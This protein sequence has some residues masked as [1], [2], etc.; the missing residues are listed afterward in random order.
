[1]PRI[2]C[3]TADGEECS[4]H[5][6]RWTNQIVLAGTD[7]AR[8]A[9]PELGASRRLDTF[10]EW[11]A[12]ST[13][14][15]KLVCLSHA[16]QKHDDC[17]ATQQRR[18]A[19]HNYCNN[20]GFIEILRVWN[21]SL[22]NNNFPGRSDTGLHNCC[23]FGSI[24]YKA[25][26]SSG[27]SGDTSIVMMDSP[28]PSEELEV[29]RLHSTISVPDIR[30]GHR[31]VHVLLGSSAPRYLCAANKIL[32]KLVGNPNISVR[33]I[34]PS[35]V[36]DEFGGLGEHDRCTEESERIA[37]ELCE[38][39][40]L[41]VLAPIEADAFARMLHGMTGNT[42][43]EV[44]R[45]WDVSKKAI[46]VPG[47][48]TA[49]WKNPMT[50]KQLNKV[51]R[52]WNWVRVLQPM[53]WQFEGAETPPKRNTIWEGMEE[54]IGIIIN[55][56]E[57]MIIGQ[58]VDMTTGVST[59]TSK[60]G[61]SPAT[62]PPEI[63]SSI[64]EYLGDWE[65]STRLGIYTR[66]P[67]PPEWKKQKEQV[68]DMKD[69]DWIILTGSSSDVAAWLQS[70]TA[71]LW[72]SSLCVKL[73]I[74]FAWT[75][76]LSYLE[77]DHE[78]LFW[79]TFG[80]TLLPTKA[81]AVFGRVEVLEWWRTSPS[82][83]T[84]EYTAEAVDGA[85]RVGFVHALDWWRKSGL[86]MCYTEAALEQASSRGNVEVLEWW[87][88]ASMHQG[89]YNTVSDASRHG[90]SRRSAA[91]Y[92]GHHRSAS[93]DITGPLRLKVGK[94]ICLAAQNGQVETIRWWDA[95]GIPYLH[96]ES[97]AK[98]ASTYG[99]VKVLQL[100]KE[101][102]GGKMIYDNQVLVGPTKN[103]HRDVLEW[104]R[105]SG[106]KVEYKTCDIEEALEDC[107]G[108]FATTEEVKK[109][110]ARNGLNLGVGTSEW[111]RVKVL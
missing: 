58:D 40:D 3:S 99:H 102:K 103:G 107:V 49:M 12:N 48:S 55:Q 13:S 95:S 105:N 86:P 77:R 32:A 25:F 33:L 6:R 47:M 84:R 72:L 17:T 81:S 7:V 59:N 66:L 68:S 76:L 69:L 46:L 5:G 89:Y 54:L 90:A 38:W 73:I 41:L 10:G 43:L 39:A 74:K 11:T 83:L 92:A 70:R 80:H 50:K 16:M 21:Y 93:A 35:W 108:G 44:L 78:D 14:T 85:S 60:N 36:V 30:D 27:D 106:F 94:S 63:W 24:C 42:V 109:W 31:K 104:W 4:S 18:E 98:I 26:R 34:P 75:E 111:M 110:W 45:S 57:L 8:E 97:V 79:A 88:T 65:L 15:D 23:L 1:M 67:V 96:E 2:P 28:H 9:S 29:P 82:F 100:W 87:K 51:R 22:P 71:P 53:L 37:A 52:K 101:L 20:S 91:M 61:P 64:F 62:L 19:M 56:V